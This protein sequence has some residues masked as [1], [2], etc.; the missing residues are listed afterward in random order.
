MI[1]YSIYYWDNDAQKVYVANG[2]SYQQAVR[3][4]QKYCHWYNADLHH[5]IENG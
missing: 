5:E 3:Y 2:L 4:E 1:K